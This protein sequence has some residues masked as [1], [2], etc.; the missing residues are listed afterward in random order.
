[1]INNPFSFTLQ[2]LTI[3]VIVL[4]TDMTINSQG[5][6]GRRRRGNTNYY[7]YGGGGDNDKA[8]DVP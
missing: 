1:M 5:K 8:V 2:N 4:M 7:D 6:K 3:L